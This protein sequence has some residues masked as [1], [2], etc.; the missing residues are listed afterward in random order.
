MRASR[1]KRSCMRALWRCSACST[2]MATRRPSDSCSARNTS[3]HAAGAERLDEHE[4]ADA[5]TRPERCAP[6]ERDDGRQARYSSLPRRPL[7]DKQSVEALARQPGELGGATDVVVRAREER[8]QILFFEGRARRLQRRQL[9][10]AAE[11]LDEIEHG[12]AVGR[13]LRARALDDVAQLAHVARP[14]VL[15]EHLEPR[16]RQR[17]GAVEELID[18]ERNVLA[19]L[20]AAAESPRASTVRR[21]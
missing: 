11:G 21:K 19:P 7:R 3:S 17:R 18:E 15:L 1:A 2:L 14:V 20:L 4:A 13:L 9:G 12:R 6:M 5:I 10:A 16:H 8:A